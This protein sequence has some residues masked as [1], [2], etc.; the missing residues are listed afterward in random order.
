M[1]VTKQLKKLQA[2]LDASTRER[3][4]QRDE[5]KELLHKLKSKEKH[6]AEKAKGE[7]DSD[8]KEHLNHEVALL[9]AQR[10]KGIRV[11]KVLND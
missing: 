5:L 7:S 9:H 2:M 4:K 10:K 8:R 1:N 3:F 11:L 6:L